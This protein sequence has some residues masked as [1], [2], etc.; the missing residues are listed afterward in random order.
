MIRRFERRPHHFRISPLGSPWSESE[1]AVRSI[2]SATGG[3]ASAMF[4]RVRDVALGAAGD[5]SDAESAA[6]EATS[7]VCP[8]M[9][10]KLVKALI[11]VSRVVFYIVEIRSYKEKTVY[12]RSREI[13]ADSPLGRKKCKREQAPMTW[14]RGKEEKR[15]E[16]E[17]GDADHSRTQWTT[18]FGL[19]QADAHRPLQTSDSTRRNFSD[20][21]KDTQ[22]FSPLL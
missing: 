6:A 7:S 15:K 12:T 5:R 17:K 21:A 20:S 18:A 8:F 3:L 2:E 11:Q 22:S 16:G 10:D 19:S 1:S 9:I 14:R 13:G 4:V